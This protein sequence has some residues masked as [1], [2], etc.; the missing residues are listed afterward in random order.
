M[1]ERIFTDMKEKYKKLSLAGIDPGTNDSLL[2]N[3][4]ISNTRKV[5]DYVGLNE[6]FIFDGIILGVCINGTGSI[7]IN[8]REY[9]INKSG[10][11]CI[12]PNNICKMIKVSDDFLFELMFFSH[13]YMSS[14]SLP[15][16]KDILLGVA[17][18]PIIEINEV[19]MQDILEIH[20][21]II[22]QHNGDLT[23][24]ERI[25]KALVSVLILQIGSY[26]KIN[27]EKNV[28][29]EYSREEELTKSFFNLL[30]D[31]F[32]EEKELPFYADKLCLTSNYL[33]SVI[34]K[35]T[36]YSIREWI[37]S[38]VITE[39]K[40]KL[41]TTDLTILQISED[42]NFANPS[43]FGRYFKQYTGMTPL[44]F[45]NS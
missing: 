12:L 16:E 25:I 36:G 22:K 32:R 3:Y 37:R 17:E 4:I 45:R 10:I 38:V 35:M 23:Y 44:K 21:V 8:H 2:K 14:F 1:N 29:K 31:N 6:S 41:K 9:E 13:D 24:K 15:L 39:A 33:S 11:T 42:L 18:N 26:Y 34:K 43:F 7:K 40:N 5:P 28:P 19:E 30:M 27:T 20:S